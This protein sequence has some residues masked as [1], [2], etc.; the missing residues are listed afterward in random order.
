MQTQVA[1]DKKFVPYQNGP[2]V[3]TT[4]SGNSPYHAEN[5]LWE[6]I[7]L[8]HITNTDGKVEG[9]KT[10]DKQELSAAEAQALIE[11]YLVARNNFSDIPAEY[12]TEQAQRIYE[13]NYLPARRAE[14]SQEE[15]RTFP[16]PW[17]ESTYRIPRKF[18][19]LDGREIHDGTL[20]MNLDEDQINALRNLANDPD[21]RRYFEYNP[22]FTLNIVGNVET[23][24]KKAST[25]AATEFFRSRNGITLTSQGIFIEVSN[26]FTEHDEAKFQLQ[27]LGNG[28]TPTFV[29]V[30]VNKRN[31][32]GP[33]DY[34]LIRNAKNV[35]SELSGMTSGEMKQSIAKNLPSK[36]S[37]YELPVVLRI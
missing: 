24:S 28:E 36:L 35:M 27:G 14:L 33:I 16:K 7:S 19:Q 34:Y 6:Q 15:P 12:F 17:H 20:E 26:D 32:T 37:P 1:W 11:V 10:T 18:T 30:E 13:N 22:D 5:Y 23:G 4:G 8:L 21:L 25:E 29:L 3:F 2:V 9:Y 31:H